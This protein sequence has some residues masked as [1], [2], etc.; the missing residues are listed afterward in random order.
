MK[1]TKRIMKL[2]LKEKNIVSAEIYIY[3]DG[4]MKMRY[5]DETCNKRL[6]KSC[7]EKIKKV[8]HEYII[9]PL[10]YIKFDEF[11]DCKVTILATNPYKN[12]PF[13]KIVNN[14]PL[15]NTILRLIDD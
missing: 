1:C 4:Y 3:E 10:D 2:T 8:L 14:R 12:R 6:E 13:T 9:N 15:C 5:K 11:K 7:L